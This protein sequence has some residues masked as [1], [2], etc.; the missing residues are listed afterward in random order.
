MAT[1]L[2]RAEQDIGVCT[3]ILNIGDF[4]N[5]IRI[6]E[7]PVTEDDT[8]VEACECEFHEWPDCKSCCP[9]FDCSDCGCHDFGEEGWTWTPMK[10]I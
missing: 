5:A 10:S 7:L 8:A 6:A 1:E 2:H 9:C 3:M 4:S